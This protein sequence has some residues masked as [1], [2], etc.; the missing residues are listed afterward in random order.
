MFAHAGADST[1][2][3]RHDGRAQTLTSSGLPL[4]IQR[5]AEYGTLTCRLEPGDTLL[6]ATDGLTE[7]RQGGELLGMEGL[8]RLATEA[9]GPAAPAGVG[10]AHLAQSQG[11][12][13]RLPP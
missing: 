12:R 6:L 11:L 4:G 3:L 8:T 5:S 1:L 2:V 7:A 9:L 13:G 10:A